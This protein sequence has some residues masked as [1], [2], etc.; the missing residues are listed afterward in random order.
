MAADLFRGIDLHD[1]NMSGASTYLLRIQS[2]AD[3]AR[4]TVLD[5]CPVHKGGWQVSLRLPELV[6]GRE[7]GQQVCTAKQ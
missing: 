1:E 4:Y 7:L 5:V 3:F 6:H 2:G